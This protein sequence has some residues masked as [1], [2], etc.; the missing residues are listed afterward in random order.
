MTN[1]I[2]YTGLL[3]LVQIILPMPLASRSEEAVAERARRALHNLRESLPVFFVLA[4]LSIHSDVQANTMIASIWLSLRVVF[5]LIY[6]TGFNSQPPSDSGYVGQPLRSLAWFGS[7]FCLI[8]MG[9]N[10]I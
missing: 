5:A 1:I 3:Y 2:L 10:L 8:M 7:I 9:L 4:V 6:V